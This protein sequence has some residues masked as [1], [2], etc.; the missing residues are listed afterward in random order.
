[1][2]RKT[3]Q[4]AVK[5]SIILFFILLVGILIYSLFYY[6]EI[7]CNARLEFEK[8]TNCS[9]Q[10]INNC[11]TEGFNPNLNHNYLGEK[12]FVYEFNNEIIREPICLCECLGCKK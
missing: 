12:I 1:M 6:K 10:C 7:N 4:T 8:M 5:I 9:E 3:I 2:E 11:I